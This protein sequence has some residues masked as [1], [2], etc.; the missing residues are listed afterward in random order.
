MAVFHRLCSGAAA[1]PGGG[2]L[3][4]AVVARARSL[5]LAAPDAAALDFGELDA[6]DVLE[7]LGL[8][9]E[10]RTRG[11][12]VA[13]QGLLEAFLRQADRCELVAV[14]TATDAWLAQ[15]T[16]D[17]RS[18]GF[19]A[20]SAPVRPEGL[21]S[22]VTPSTELV[23]ALLLQDTSRVVP[24]TLYPQSM[25]RACG[26]FLRALA[27]TSR[28]LIHMEVGTP[29]S[30]QEPEPR[31]RHALFGEDHVSVPFRIDGAAGVAEFSWE[32]KY[33]LRVDTAMPALNQAVASAGLRWMIV[34]ADGDRGFALFEE[35]E[36]LRLRTE[37][38]V[39][40]SDPCDVPC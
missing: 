30:V 15:L 5:G 4:A 10:L 39:A 33:L 8:C 40:L 12:A 6:E 21:G 3:V 34:N 20:A 23:A 11:A 2:R 16:D 32:S 25:E 7:L 18:F 31:T 26:D 9:V 35:A 28:G 14:P 29:T 36:I 27:Q 24:E 1:L 17:L 19:F 13:S 22:T 38:G 37:L